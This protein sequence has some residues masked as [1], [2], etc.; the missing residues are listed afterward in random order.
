M[1]IIFWTTLIKGYNNIIKKWWP[2]NYIF[3]LIFIILATVGYDPFERDLLR[4]RASIIGDT[5]KNLI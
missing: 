2:W 4:D 3:H 5:Q 1:T